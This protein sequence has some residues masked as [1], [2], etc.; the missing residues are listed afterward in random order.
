MES[1]RALNLISHRSPQSI[2]D[3]RGWQGATIEERIGPWLAS[4]VGT[5]ILAYGATRRSW[6][7]V[8]L[9]VGGVALIGCAAA[10]LCNP[11]H[12]AV[13]LRHMRQ[14]RVDRVTMESMDSFPASD[15]PSSNAIAGYDDRA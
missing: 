7:G 2:W 5:G 12:A 11:R 6:R 9:M 1:N 8:W 10:G 3:K 4:V 13:R 15:A 14:S